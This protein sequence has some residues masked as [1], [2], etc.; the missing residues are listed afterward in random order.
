MKTIHRH[1]WPLRLMRTA[2]VFILCVLINRLDPINGLVVFL[3]VICYGAVNSLFIFAICD[4]RGWTRTRL[5]SIPFYLFFMA[6]DFYY[7]HGFWVHGILFLAGA[8]VA[9]DNPWLLDDSETI[10]DPA[11]QTIQA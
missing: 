4:E 1:D 7:T 11:E 3:V 6:F 10:A 9:S 8:F 5:A 2:I